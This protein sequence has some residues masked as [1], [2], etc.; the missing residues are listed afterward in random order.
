MYCSVSLSC[1]AFWPL[2]PL[3]ECESFSKDSTIPLASCKI[4]SPLPWP[5]RMADY[6]IPSAWLILA[7]LSPS[8]FKIL[9]LL[10]LSLSAYSSILLLICSGGLMSL[11]SY[12]MQSIPHFLEAS[13]KDSLMFE[14][15]LSLSS[16]VL[17]NSI[18]P[19]SL[20]ID[21]WAS[22]ARALIGYDTS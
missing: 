2:F 18:L 22:K 17:S 10:I 6:L 1:K 4:C 7:S 21:V 20:L 3:R 12:L 13:F 9:L 11:I 8:E 5:F 16:K 14:L 15:R 19:I